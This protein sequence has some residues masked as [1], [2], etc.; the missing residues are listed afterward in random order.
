MQKKTKEQ[1]NI[2]LGD[3]FPFE[4][5]AFSNHKEFKDGVVKETIY[6]NGKKSN[7]LKKFFQK[8]KSQRYKQKA[9]QNSFHIG[10][11]NGEAG[12]W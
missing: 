12:H 5:S 9:C 7:K 8:I 11:N 3:I 6:D 10:C 4:N 1:P 2:S